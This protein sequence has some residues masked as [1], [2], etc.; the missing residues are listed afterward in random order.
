MVRAVRVSVRDR[1]RD[2]VTCTLHV[3]LFCGPLALYT[4]VA[5]FEKRPSQFSECAYAVSHCVVCGY[6]WD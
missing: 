5:L 2:Y 4:V 3:F 6:I 1:G